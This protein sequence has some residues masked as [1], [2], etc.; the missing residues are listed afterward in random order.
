MPRPVTGSS[1]S[2]ERP[3]FSSCR[4]IGLGLRQARSRR[5]QVPV[6]LPAAVG[7]R[8]RQL[9]AEQNVAPSLLLAVA[10]AALLGRLG[11]Q[12]EL[13]LGYSDGEGRERL[14]L[15]FDFASD[16]GLDALFEQAREQLAASASHRYDPAAVLDELGVAQFA[17]SH[18]VF[19]AAFTCG[20]Q[21]GADDRPATGYRTCPGFLRPY[22]VGRDWLRRRHVRCQ[23]DPALVLPFRIPAR[24]AVCGRTTTS[25]DLNCSMSVSVGACSWK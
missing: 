12:P 1:V 7:T 19:Q 5:E 13:V 8:L 16:P 18:P 17:G 6:S 15:R 10:W 25:R 14:P 9:A 21:R 22:A 24:L 23:F 20:R 11:T 3:A 2:R 4:S